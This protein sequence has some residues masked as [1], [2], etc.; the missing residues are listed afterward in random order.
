MSEP[1]NRQ[2]NSM[3][4]N[5]KSG[6]KDDP[7][8]EA[9]TVRPSG[10]KDVANVPTP[11]TT[12]GDN[13]TPPRDWVAGPRGQKAPNSQNVPSPKSS[14][15]KDTPNMGTQGGKGKVLPNVD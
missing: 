14:G 13:L 2:V 10:S 11:R 3:V 1:V 5:R 7:M 9:K 12:S 6:S 8:A 15:S 4:Q